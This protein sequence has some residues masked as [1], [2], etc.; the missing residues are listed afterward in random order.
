MPG[1]DGARIE[2]DVGQGVE[3]S[4]HYL[5]VVGTDAVGDAHQLLAAVRAGYGAELAALHGVVDG[6]EVGGHHVDAAGIAHQ[7]NVVAQL[8]GAK[9]YVEGGAVVVD[10]QLRSGD[11]AFFVHTCVSY[12][13]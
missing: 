8:V 5:D 9:V 13:V 6:V 12:K 11:Y 1:L 10:D 2:V 4:H 7:N 3:L